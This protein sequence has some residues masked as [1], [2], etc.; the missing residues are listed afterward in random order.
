M[1]ML[2]RIRDFPIVPYLDFLQCIIQLPIPRTSSVDPCPTTVIFKEHDN[3]VKSWSIIFLWMPHFLHL[4]PELVVNAIWS[5]EAISW[6]RFS[7]FRK[8]K[9]SLT[10]LLKCPSIRKSTVDKYWHTESH[11]ISTQNTFEQISS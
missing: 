9:K 1:K 2:I 7:N 6:L 5:L 11:L 10:L 4:G 3:F 8:N